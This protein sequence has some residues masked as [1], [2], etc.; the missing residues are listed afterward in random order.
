MEMSTEQLRPELQTYV[1]KVKYL[2]GHFQ[3]PKQ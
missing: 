2:N 1:S 3:F